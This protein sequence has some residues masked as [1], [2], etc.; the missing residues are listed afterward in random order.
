MRSIYAATVA[1]YAAAPDALKE[2]HRL[3]GLKTPYWDRFDY[4]GLASAPRIKKAVSAALEAGTPIGAGGSR[5]LRENCEEHER[6]EAE[7]AQFFKAETSLF[8]GGGYV[9]NFAILTTRPSAAICSFSILSCTEVFTKGRGW[10]SRISG[11]RAQRSALGRTH[12]FATGEP[13]VEQAASGSWSKVSTA[14]MAI[15]RLSTT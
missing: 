4:L 10:P 6:L 2:D 12:N 7:A 11:K 1:D 14:W 8:F 3:R 15:L 13:K 9:A 5:L